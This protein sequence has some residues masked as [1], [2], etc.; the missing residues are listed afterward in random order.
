MRQA[1]RRAIRNRA[2]R[3]AVRTYVKKAGEAVLQTAENA[4]EVVRAA[5]SALDKAAHKGIVHPNA[6][7]RRKSRLMGR[8]HALA[9]APSE[10]AEPA[11][12]A[13]PKAKAAVTAAKS[14]AK[15]ATAAPK[16]EAEKKPAAA[17]ALKK[18][19]ARKPA[20]KPKD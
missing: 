2:A 17:S 18:P 9:G 16:A 8:L 6:A 5:V 20:A 19:A 13:A 15:R 10:S 1:E 12:K 11:A 3:S 14:P 4:A 7:A